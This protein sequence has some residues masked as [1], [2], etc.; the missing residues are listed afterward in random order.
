MCSRWWAVIFLVPQA[1]SSVVKFYPLLGMWY[2]NLLFGKCGFWK[3]WPQLLCL[4]DYKNHFCD[5][6]N[7][8][9]PTYFYVN[10]D[11]Y[12][13]LIMWYAWVW[14]W[15]F[16]AFLVN[17]CTSTSSWSVILQ[18]RW[19]EDG[20]KEELWEIWNF[21][22]SILLFYDNFHLRRTF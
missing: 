3:T 9:I 21:L 8:L 17:E 7:S 1:H 4:T 20:S 13:Y 14:M 10:F 2:R 6:H 18:R 16:A 22:F 19:F 15:E 11:H 5:V 12:F